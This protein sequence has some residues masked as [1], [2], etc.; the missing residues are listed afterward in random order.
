[1]TT[2]PKDTVAFALVINTGRGGWI[3]P[4]AV[5]WTRDDVVRFAC[6]WWESLDA[7]TPQQKWT[8]LRKERGYRIVKVMVSPIGDPR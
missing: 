3:C 5:C 4:S 1:M 6:S 8:R 2:Q 7:E